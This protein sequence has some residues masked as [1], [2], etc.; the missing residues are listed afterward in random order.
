M[1][2]SVCNENERPRD[3]CEADDITPQRQG[4]EAKGT[5]DRRPGDFD[6]QP[7]LVVDQSEEGHLVDDQG[8]E[9]IVEDGQLDQQISMSVNVTE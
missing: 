5:E 6:V 1:H 3:H 4:V 9:T 7:V 2:G 8:L